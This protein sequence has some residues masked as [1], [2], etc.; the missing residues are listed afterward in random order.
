M[1]C[2]LIENG[3]WFIFKS[4]EEFDKAVDRYNSGEDLTGWF[5]KG[6]MSSNMDENA[7]AWYIGTIEKQ[8]T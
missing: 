5:S 7:R 4:Q 8:T 3:E 2:I 6:K 1:E